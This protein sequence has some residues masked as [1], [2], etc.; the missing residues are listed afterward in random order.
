MGLKLETS[1]SPRTIANKFSG[2][3]GYLKPFS[4]E[5]QYMKVFNIEHGVLY[6]FE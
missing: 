1:Q 3:E 2:S 4:N 6:L 5:F